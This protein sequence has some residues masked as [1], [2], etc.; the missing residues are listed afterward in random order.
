MHLRR[1]GITGTQSLLALYGTCTACKQ[2]GATTS[3]LALTLQGVFPSSGMGKV[4]H[5][6]KFW[7]TDPRKATASCYGSVCPH[8]SA[9]ASSGEG[10]TGPL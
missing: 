6:A 10:L 8:H 4:A 2:Q 7:L 9:R 3:C 5:T 1:L